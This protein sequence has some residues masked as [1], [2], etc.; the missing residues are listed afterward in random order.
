[1]DA[2]RITI[3]GEPTAQGRARI[4]TVNGFP[5]A[6]EP[7]KSRDWKRYASL[8]ASEQMK[9]HP[10]MDGPLTM[11]IHVFRQIPRSWSKKKQTMAAQGIVRPVSKPD[12]DN[13][14]KSAMDALKGIVWTDDSQVVSLM[15]VKH[16]SENPRLEMCVR[17][18][19]CNEEDFDA[20][21]A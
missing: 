14:V 11:Q 10:V 19:D 7:A 20:G 15:A 2:V 21:I 13:Y 17:R 9:G 18:I 1:M 8:I 4:S 6:Y 5:M 16:Y 3:A 12:V